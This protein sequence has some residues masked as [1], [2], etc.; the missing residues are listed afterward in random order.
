MSGKYLKRKLQDEAYPIKK[1]VI[2]SPLEN[3]LNNFVPT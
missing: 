1:N 2:V 3:F